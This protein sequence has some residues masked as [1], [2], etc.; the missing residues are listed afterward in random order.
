[1]VCADSGREIPSWHRTDT[2]VKNGKPREKAY[3]LTDGYDQSNERDLIAEMLHP[4]APT[5]GPPS[6]RKPVKR[7]L[8]EY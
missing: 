6:L 4:L 8:I 7:T 1:M 2:A 5:I 3:K